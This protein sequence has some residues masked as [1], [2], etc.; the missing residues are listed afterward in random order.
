VD[1]WLA[2]AAEQLGEAPPSREEVGGTLRLARD[3]ARGVER[4][5]APLA[6]YLAGV[7]VGRRAGAGAARN[8]AFAEV[9]EA[10][11]PLIPPPPEGPGDPPAGSG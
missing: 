3:V 5:M 6:A 1:E 8:D 10:L 4:K 11:R 2:A 9:T 7:A